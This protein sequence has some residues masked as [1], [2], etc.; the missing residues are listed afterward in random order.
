MSIDRIGLSIDRVDVNPAHTSG[1]PHCG[2]CLLQERTL[3]F[4]LSSSTT[5]SGPCSAIQQGMDPK[6]LKERTEKFANNVVALCVPLLVDRP[7]QNERATAYICRGFVCDRPVT[8]VA[9][10]TA[11]LTT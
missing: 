5:R 10:L 7:L 11:R 3:R 9:E 4:A 1:T 8:D 6:K 2:N